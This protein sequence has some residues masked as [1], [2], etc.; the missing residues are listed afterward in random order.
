VRGEYKDPVALLRSFRQRFE[1]SQAIDALLSDDRLPLDALARIL[2][3]LVDFYDDP[4]I[5]TERPPEWQRERSRH[6]ARERKLENEIAVLERSL[7]DAQSARRWSLARGF[8]RE[9]G[10]RRDALERLGSIRDDWE[11]R[12][13]PGRPLLPP[14]GAP[15][16]TD[17]MLAE[18]VEMVL[19]R[20]VPVPPGEAPRWLDPP[21]LAPPER[22]RVIAALVSD[23]FQSATPEQIRALLKESRRRERTTLE[24]KKPE[25]GPSP[26]RPNGPTF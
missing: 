4:K 19:S 25:S 15:K 6:L 9:L 13:P 1:A 22:Q 12:A 24:K 2:Q 7:R 8:E 3:Q 16:R 11:R 23:F 17:T 21:H 18:R 26:P 20:R 5:P 14:A 10:W